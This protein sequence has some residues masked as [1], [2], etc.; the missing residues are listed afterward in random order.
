MRERSGRSEIEK[1]TNV[2]SRSFSALVKAFE[3]HGADLTLEHTEKV[4]RYLGNGLASAQQKASLA[5]QIAAGS[6]SLD[7]EL[8]EAASPAI[9]TPLTG[10]APQ[11]PLN[12]KVL[13]I[14]TGKP[15]RIRVARPTNQDGTIDKTVPPA[16][17]FV[18]PEQPET[19]KPSAGEIPDKTG[20]ISDAG[21]IE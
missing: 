8:P 3:K 9:T 4:F 6:F 2:V 20:G 14:S 18:E 10:A 5:R 15:Q 13:M 12:S 11:T 21:F 16:F 7:S 17:V 1:A 19:Y